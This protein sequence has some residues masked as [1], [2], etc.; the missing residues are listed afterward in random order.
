LHAC[1][2]HLLRKMARFR[3]ALVVQKS[4]TTGTAF[5]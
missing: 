4:T 5:A 3:E 2:D 1:R